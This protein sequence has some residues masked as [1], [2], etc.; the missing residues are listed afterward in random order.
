MRKLSIS[1]YAPG[2]EDDDGGVDMLPV[3]QL[4]CDEKI[5]GIQEEADI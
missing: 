4:L 1:L 5:T 3:I 2:P